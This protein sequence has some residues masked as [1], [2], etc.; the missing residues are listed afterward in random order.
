MTGSATPAFL[1]TT[2]AIAEMIIPFI[3]SDSI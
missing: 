1:K 2:P 3:I